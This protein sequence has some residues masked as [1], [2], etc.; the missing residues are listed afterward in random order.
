[1][2]I[3]ITNDDG[4]SDGGV[5]TL[6]NVLNDAGHNV[7]MVAPENNKS[8]ISAALTLNRHLVV[9]NHG[10]NIWSLDGNPCDCVI[11][12]FYSDILGGVT[13]D[14]LISGINDGGNIGTDITYSGTC[15]AARQ[16][17]IYHAPSI[18]LSMTFRTRD[19]N[20]PLVYSSSDKIPYYKNL[21]Q[22]VTNNIERLAGYAKQ[23]NC[24]AF[25]NINVYSFN[26]WV[27][28]KFCTT[29]SKRKYFDKVVITKTGETGIAKVYGK[30]P[31]SSAQES[32]DFWACSN[33]YIALSRVLAEPYAVAF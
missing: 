16:G 5:N 32:C 26:K 29:L 12:A 13:P 15:A 21:A 28:E 10:K 18:A 2:N 14:L 11:T 31:A 33:G 22:Y 9:K 23:N 27:G 4:Y 20:G 19:E 7:F 17:S 6:F 30:E 24:E 8:A 25:L 3:L 1:M